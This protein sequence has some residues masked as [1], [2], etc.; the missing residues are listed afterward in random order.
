MSDV[1]FTIG[2]SVHSID[3]FIALLSQHGITAL[4][5]I[6]SRPYSRMNPQ[7]NRE[8]LK[9]ALKENGIAYIFL[10]QE[11]G[12]KSNDASCYR[13][14][15][16]QYDRLAQ[17]DLFRQGIERVR[18]GMQGYRLALMCAEKEPLDCHRTILIARCLEALQ[19]KVEHILEDGSLESQ[20]N[21]LRRLLA[22]LKLPEQDLFRSRE[23]MIEE[24][25]RIQGERI[26]YE[27]SQAPSDG[28][29][30]M[31]SLSR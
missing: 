28:E 8:N 9:Q 3:R 13:S 11:L 24:A 7:F 31:R 2:H 20:K 25:Y 10:G 17:T 4:G 18:V 21:A 14:G 5:D 26:A 16:L 23:D 30:P 1:V 15:K 12:A 6:R 27:A 19:I 22:L 29:R